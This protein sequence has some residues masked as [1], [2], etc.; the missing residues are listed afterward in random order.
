MDALKT[1]YICIGDDIYKMCPTHASAYPIAISCFP[2]VLMGSEKPTQNISI[3]LNNLWSCL[4]SSYFNCSHVVAFSASQYKLDVDIKMHL[5][6]LCFW[7]GI[8]LDWIEGVLIPRNHGGV[9]V[10]WRYVSTKH[11]YMFKAFLP[12]LLHLWMMSSDDTQIN[13]VVGDN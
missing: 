3:N 5:R 13:W 8:S 1:M 6:C 10:S 9:E 12:H 2:N 4:L 7:N 11:V